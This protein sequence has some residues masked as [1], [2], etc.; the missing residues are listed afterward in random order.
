MCEKRRRKRERDGDTS[1]PEV[2]HRSLCRILLKSVFLLPV[3]VVVIIVIAVK[4][5]VARSDKKTM[6][7]NLNVP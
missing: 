5:A 6:L 2:L 3:L 7:G 4:N 1:L